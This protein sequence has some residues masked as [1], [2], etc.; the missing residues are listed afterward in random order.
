MIV[1]VKSSVKK[2]QNENLQKYQNDVVIAKYMISIIYKN[3]GGAF[4]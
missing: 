4:R 1:P 3:E 2:Q